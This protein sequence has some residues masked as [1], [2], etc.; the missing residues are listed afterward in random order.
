MEAQKMELE[1]QGREIT[2]LSNDIR[3]NI[4]ANNPERIFKLICEM[5][6]RCKIIVD[7]LNDEWCEVLDK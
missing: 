6:K 4:E 7:I 3:H 5:D 1:K 2:R